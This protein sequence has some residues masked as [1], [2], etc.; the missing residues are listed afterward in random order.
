MSNF[1]SHKNQ[2]W[3][4]V[5]NV[6]P[7][8]FF[9]T[10]LKWFFKKCFERILQRVARP[11]Q[12]HYCRSDYCIRVHGPSLSYLNKLE[13]GG[14]SVSGS[15]ESLDMTKV[16]IDLWPVSS[17]VA[18]VLSG[19]Q[20]DIGICCNRLI[21]IADTRRLEMDMLTGVKVVSGRDR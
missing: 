15:N 8:W 14:V 10:Q 2:D 17:E 18:S 5:A 6:F 12:H 20:Y 4:H 21:S 9:I 1:P 13:K 16:H 7:S 11:K 19:L 3:F